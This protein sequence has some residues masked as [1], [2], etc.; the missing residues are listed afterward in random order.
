MSAAAQARQQQAGHDR[1][2]R[3]IEAHFRGR[4]RPAAEQDLR[5]HLPQCWD[6]RTHYERYLAFS[7]L[8]PRAPSAEQRMARGL[9]LRPRAP[10]PARRWWSVAALALAGAAVIALAP[11]VR[12]PPAPDAE[13]VARGG[14]LGQPA[15]ALLLYRIARGGDRAVPADETLARDDE[16]A[17]AY[18]NPVGKPFLMVFGVDEDRRVYWYHPAWVRADENPVSVAISA[19]PGLHEL[20]AAVAHDLHGQRLSIHALFS[21][22]AFSVREIETALARDPQRDPQSPL[23]LPDAVDIAH[24]YR[25]GP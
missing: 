8:D 7:A 13:F 25:T 22:R 17:F 18:R 12:R 10:E 5:A 3:A 1:A 2:R 11:V 21:K 23:S 20:P 4:A 14:G 6:C 9:G 15:E 16:L 24:T 19:A